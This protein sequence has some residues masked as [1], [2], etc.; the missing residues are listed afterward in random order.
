[1]TKI[2]PEE[3]RRE[4]SDWMKGLLGLAVI[5][6]IIVVGYVV[7]QGIKGN[8]TQQETKQAPVTKPVSSPT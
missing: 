2:S 1:M 6:C 7:F 8:L 5:L 4:A 3:K